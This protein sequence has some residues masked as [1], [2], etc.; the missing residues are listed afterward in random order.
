MDPLAKEFK[1]EKLYQNSFKSITSYPKFLRLIKKI[2]PD[3]IHCQSFFSTLLD[4][5]LLRAAKKIADSK[6]VITPH[7][8]LPHR[9]KLHHARVFKELYSSADRII[10]HSESFKTAM[11]DIFGLD[12]SKIEIIPEGNSILNE[13]PGF[14]Q[15][16]AKKALGLSPGDK[17]ILFFG[18]IR[19]HKGLEY[20]I[21]AFNQV[22]ETL[23]ETKLII[24]GNPIN[25]F[26][27]YRELID[28]LGLKEDIITDLRY[29]PC[30]E[31]SKYFKASDIVALPYLRTVHS[32]VI[33]MAYAFGKPVV[34]TLKQVGIVDDG[35]SGLLVPAANDEKLADAIITAL[36]DKRCLNRMR[37][38]VIGK[39]TAFSW[40]TIAKKTIRVYES[41]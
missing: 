39:A 21:R 5:F 13:K 41:S 29:I 24:A 20:L 18:Y 31:V 10:T 9:M 27:R 40:K 34:T 23:P 15:Y 37:E 4:Y 14:T 19:E 1:V 3:I 26:S 32:P 16:D 11:I 33:P 6:L 8:V 36:S 22:V 12:F 35:K 17:G 2:N 25:G 28:S 38:N 7:N 30:E